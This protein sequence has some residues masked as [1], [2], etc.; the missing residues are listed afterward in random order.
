ML[1]KEQALENKIRVQKEAHDAWVGKYIGCTELATGCGKTKIAIDCIETIRDEYLSLDY[2]EPHILIVVPTEEMR[3]IDWPAEFKK[4]EV[5]MHRVKL[6]CYATL[7]KENLSKYNMVIYDECHRLTLPN[8]RNLESLTATLPKACILGLTATLPKVAYPDDADR[9]H[10]IRELLP[11]VYR[12]TT[13]EAVDLGL[14]SDFEV[15]VL[16][17]QLDATNKNIKA[18]TKLK[19]FMTTEEAQYKYLTKKLQVAS[20][21]AQADRKKEG[22]KFAAISARAQFLYNLPS[23]LRLASYCLAKIRTN[24]VRTLV[25]AGS[26][27]QANLLCGEHVYHS[28][29]TREALEKFQSKEISLLGAVKALNEGKNLT[30]PDNAVIVQVDSVDRNLVQRIGR[31]VRIRYDKMDHKATIVIL[32]ASGTADE[33]WYESAIGD[34]DSKR[35][36]VLNIKVPEDGV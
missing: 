35:I 8:L 27:E 4:W 25:F 21:Q 24:D 28:E 11:V 6:I 15:T 23:K 10:M 36:K 1:S 17:F 7:A 13:D 20:M 12:V 34:F 2:G 33:K 16:K 5:S 14:I 19:P 30:E 31:L 3:D 9:V 18:G 26:I 29:S 32:V 22:F